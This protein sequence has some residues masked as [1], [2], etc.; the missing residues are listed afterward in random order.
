MDKSRL[1][2][3]KGNAG[4][5]SE[6]TRGPAEAME[7]V[8]RRPSRRVA[9][10]GGPIKQVGWAKRQVGEAQP[11]NLTEGNARQRTDKGN[12]PG[13]SATEA[14]T[15]RSAAGNPA[16]AAPARGTKQ[17]GR[18][19]TAQNHNKDLPTAAPGTPARGRAIR[20]TPR[21]RRGLHG[22]YNI[23]SHGRFTIRR[24]Q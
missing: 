11:K 19:K 20:R 12:W 2:L 24:Q 15:G 1:N 18:L 14:T 8:Q 6:K 9:Q 7:E 22:G 10:G 17:T 13:R 4:H 23:D 5:R 3:A 21:P 16:G